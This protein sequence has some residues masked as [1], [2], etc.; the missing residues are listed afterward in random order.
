MK[1]PTAKFDPEILERI[2]RFATDQQAKLESKE[3]STDTPEVVEQS[4]V[5]YDLEK[6][7][8]ENGKL[9]LDNDRLEEELENKRQD[10]HLRKTYADNIFIYLGSYSVFCGAMVFAEGISH[11]AFH[12]PDIVLSTLVGATA[13][14]VIGLVGWVV[15]GLFKL[16]KD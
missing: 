5:L 13:V 9:K 10:R 4:K 14:S 8:L 6:Y 7:A 15:K 16:P 3:E 12:L 1:G 2:R 11:G